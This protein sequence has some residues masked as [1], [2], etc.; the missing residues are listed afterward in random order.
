VPVEHQER[1]SR[2]LNAALASVGDNRGPVTVIDR[3][4]SPYTT[5]F[6]V[7]LVTCRWPDGT[8][9]RLLCKYD[10]YD[11]DHSSLSHGH[12]GGIEYE[13]RVYTEVLRHSA[14]KTPAF[15]G[16]HRDGRTGERWIFLEYLDGALGVGKEC[17]RG[18]MQRAAEW[19]GRFHAE[20]PERYGT[21]FPRCINAYDREYY[22]GWV[23]RAEKITFSLRSAFPWMKRFFLEGMSEVATLLLAQPKTIIH[24]E[25]YPH[26][27]LFQD[28]MVYPIDW[29]SAAVGDGAIDLAALTEKWSDDVR[30]ECVQSYAAA[31]W[32][33]GD[34]P[35]DYEAALRAAR[36]YLCVRWLGRS[37]DD[38]P[39]EAAHAYCQMLEADVRDLGL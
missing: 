4:R 22:E 35:G 34:V 30:T 32:P 5:T 8:T 24:G 1:W 7:E 26:N 14:S 27:V 28:G 23:G 12:R 21:G 15:H 2:A 37:R 10:E 11:L 16:F 38:V 3:E 29:E 25:F 19:A 18:A 9:A 39:Q 13:A 20:S 31:R 17:R 36:I 6:P 33:D